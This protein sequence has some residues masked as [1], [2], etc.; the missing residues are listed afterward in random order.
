MN[1]DLVF[2]RG[3]DK[4]ISTFLS[5]FKTT[6]PALFPQYSPTSIAFTIEADYNPQWLTE[7]LQK[8]GKK[9]FLAFMNEEVI[10]YLLITKSIAGVSFADWLGVDKKNQKKGVA[11]QLLSLWKQ[12]A[13]EEG[14]HA[15][16]LWTSENNV[17][18]YK[19]RGFSCGGIFP[20]AWHGED[21]YLIYEI[22]REPDEKNF[23]KD[24]LQKVKKG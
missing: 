22:L 13:L 19:K 23:L 9:L 6:I 18:F 24:Y 16:Q 10:G 4:D 15:L 20:K 8:G 1:S 5:F 2:R 3:T 14:A 11:S 12:E 21:C 17:E 7:R